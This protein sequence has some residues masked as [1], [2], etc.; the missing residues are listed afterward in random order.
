MHGFLSRPRSEQEIF[1][2][3]SLERVIPG[4][5]KIND[6]LVTYWGSRLVGDGHG[7]TLN[8]HQKFHAL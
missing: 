2:I 6:G 7:D 1:D 8:S 5:I 4:M 3:M